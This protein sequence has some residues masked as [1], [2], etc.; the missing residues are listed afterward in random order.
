MS[1]IRSPVEL[2]HA[3][4]YRWLGVIVGVFCF[5]V[6]AKIKRTSLFYRYRVEFSGFNEYGCCPYDF[7]MGMHRPLIAWETL[8]FRLLY[9]LNA[10]QLVWLAY[11]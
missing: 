11:S 1:W 2:K 7:G 10:W 5:S 6:F 3:S 8:I 4:P 9:I